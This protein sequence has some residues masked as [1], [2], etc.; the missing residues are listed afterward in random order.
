MGGVF[1]SYR[2]LDYRIGS[3]TRCTQTLS[4]IDVTNGSKVVRKMIAL[5]SAGVAHNLKL[6]SNNPVTP[7]YTMQVGY[8]DH[9]LHGLWTKTVVLCAQGKL[10]HRV[11]PTWRRRQIA[12]DYTKPPSIEGQEFERIGSEW[13]AG[14]IRD[15]PVSR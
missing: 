8:K 1:I 6:S 14:Q 15:Y 13:H 11:A 2:L 3:G 10:A 9:S 7:C 5:A 4:D 12:G